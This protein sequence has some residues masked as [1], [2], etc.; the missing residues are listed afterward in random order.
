MFPLHVLLSGHSSLHVNSR[1]KDILVPCLFNSKLCSMEKYLKCLFKILLLLSVLK[2]HEQFHILKHNNL[3]LY[4]RTVFLI[5]SI[6][7]FQSSVWHALIYYLFYCDCLKLPSVSEERAFLLQTLM[8]VVS[9]F[10]CV[11]I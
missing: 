3:E 7:I 8:I 6:L 9:Y 1:K 2:F 4:S 11:K 5:A 10:L